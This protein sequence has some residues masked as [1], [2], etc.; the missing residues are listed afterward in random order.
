MWHSGW[1]G[2]NNFLIY[3]DFSP[4]WFHV[5]L[6]FTP[7]FLPQYIACNNCHHCFHRSNTWAFNS[8]ARKV[9]GNFLDFATG[10]RVGFLQLFSTQCLNNY[11]M[12]NNLVLARGFKQ[13]TRPK[14]KEARDET[15]K[16]SRLLD[17]CFFHSKAPVSS[18]KDRNPSK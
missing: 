13:G 7:W 18:K 3:V 2:P 10:D 1:L 15:N 4:R 8:L 12:Q 16:R 5:G 11:G 6:V 9:K 14:L 17:L